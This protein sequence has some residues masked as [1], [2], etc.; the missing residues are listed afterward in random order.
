M[1]YFGQEHLREL[2]DERVSGQEAVG[3]AISIYLRTERDQQHMPEERLRLRGLVEQA[4]RQLAGQL[5]KR[6]TAALIEPIARLVD[7]VAFWRAHTT[8]GLC[9][10]RGPDFFRVYGLPVRFE[11]RVAIN[12]NFHTRPLIEYLQ[13]PERYWVL[14]LSQGAVRLYEGNQGGCWPIDLAG[15]PRSLKEA[16]GY[17]VAQ[18]ALDFRG[19]GAVSSTEHGG[20]GS[21]AVGKGVIYNGQ[22]YGDDDDKVERKK[23]FRMVADGVQELLRDE[24]GPLILATVDINEPLFRE[25]CSI[26][27]LADQAVRANVERWSTAQL[28]EQAWPIAKRQR[29]ALVERALKHFEVG[30]GRGKL[31]TD[32]ASIG[33]LLVANQIR[34]LIME[35]GRQY[36]G[37]YDTEMGTLEVLGD[38]RSG[39]TQDSVEL[40]DELAEQAVLHGAEVVVVP[41]GRLPADSGVAAILRGT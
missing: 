36:W 31:E 16:L 11:D 20:R 2:L 17:A 18:D 33:Q 9:I 28:H 23:F 13:S 25:V 34:M 5:D 29:D 30:F 19:T 41:P 12:D 8:E 24:R 35:R 3:P 21:W 15:V 26:E 40:I 1:D 10:F 14:A 39:P 38:G 7:D 22:G 32:L 6:T 37:R 4:E 27:N